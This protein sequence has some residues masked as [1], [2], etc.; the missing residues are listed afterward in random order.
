MDFN[1][2]TVTINWPVKEGYILGDYLQIH[3]NDGSGAVDFDNPADNR[4]VPIVGHGSGNLGWGYFRWG[5]NSRWGHS[6]AYNATVGW[7]KGPWGTFSWGHGSRIIRYKRE[8][9][10]PGVWTF[11]LGAYDEL[12]NKYEGVPEEASVFEDLEPRQPTALKA[13]AYHPFTAVLTL[14]T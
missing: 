9:D 5:T 2:D 13:S 8:A 11:A 7:G 3:D 14:I 6:T 1:P 12:G 10:Q 4:K